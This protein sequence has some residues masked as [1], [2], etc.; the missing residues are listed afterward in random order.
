M[1]PEFKRMGSIVMGLLSPDHIPGFCALRTLS[2]PLRR[3]LPAPS[4]PNPEPARPRSR[5]GRRSSDWLRLPLILFALKS[6]SET[7][8]ASAATLSQGSFDLS[9]RGTASE[10][11][12]K[13]SGQ[14]FRKKGTALAGPW[15]SQKERGLQPLPSQGPREWRIKAYFPQAV[16]PCRTCPENTVALALSDESLQT[17]RLP[18][19][20]LHSPPVIASTFTQA[21]SLRSDSI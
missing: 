16:Q 12:E 4:N 7:S 21:S 8:H 15:V 18:Y 9:W 17:A 3:H 19:R 11:A 6:S 13:S 5:I 1:V 14:E 2:A 20:G 10:L